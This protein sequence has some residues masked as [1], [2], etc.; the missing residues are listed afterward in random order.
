[1]RRCI[2][3][4]DGGENGRTLALLLTC[5]RTGISHQ[6]HGQCLRTGGRQNDQ[7]ASDDTTGRGCRPPFMEGR[8]E[9]GTEC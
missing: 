7:T 6:Q 8:N 4:Q 2:E 5:C 1:M 9:T 3:S